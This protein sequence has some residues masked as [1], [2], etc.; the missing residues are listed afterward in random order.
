MVPSCNP[1]TITYSLARCGRILTHPRNAE[2]KST[3]INDVRLK[4]GKTAQNKSASCICEV[5]ITTIIGAPEVLTWQ[6][7][8]GTL[9]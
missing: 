9:R 3:A 5:F 4:G 8:S 6:A 1:A 7:E 2:A